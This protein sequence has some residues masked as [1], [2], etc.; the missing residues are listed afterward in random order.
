MSLYYTPLVKCIF[1]IRS[2]PPFESTFPKQHVERIK[3]PVQNRLLQQTV[4]ALPYKPNAANPNKDGWVQIY[5]KLQS[6]RR[7]RLQG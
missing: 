4:K 6:I 3:Q 2:E 1:L 5:I 7:T